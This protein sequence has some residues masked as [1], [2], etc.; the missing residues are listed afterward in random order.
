MDK[1]ALHIVSSPYVL[2]AVICVQLRQKGK[3]LLVTCKEIIED[4]ACNST[5]LG[6]R[7]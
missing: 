6:G 7:D 5:C 1:T 4:Y 2:T 3:M